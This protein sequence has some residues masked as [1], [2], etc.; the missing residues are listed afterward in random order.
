MEL[1]SLIISLLALSISGVVGYFYLESVI[2]QAK[3]EYH[4]NQPDVQIL[5]LPS[6]R[7]GENLTLLPTIRN[8][9]KVPAYNCVLTIDGWQ[10]QIAV[11]TLYPA[12]PKFR[13]HGV[14]ILIGPEQPIRSTLVENAHLRL[15]YS[16]YWGGQYEV[17]YLVEQAK[18]GENRIYDLNIRLDTP[19]HAW[20]SPTYLEIRKLLKNLPTRQW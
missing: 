15:R 11:G 7:T 18:Q 6:T 1:A 9:S 8:V 16:D 5:N 4:D 2:E 10:G 13:E 3:K 14:S 12:G 17:T 20:P 19:G